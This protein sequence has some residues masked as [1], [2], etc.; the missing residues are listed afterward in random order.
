MQAVDET[1]DFIPGVAGDD[2][3]AFLHLARIEIQ[4]RGGATRCYDEPRRVG[5]GLRAAKFAL[6]RFKPDTRAIEFFPDV[7]R[8]FKPAFFERC[9]WQLNAPAS[10]GSARTLT[11]PQI[12]FKSTAADTKA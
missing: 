10:C 9:E 6:Y 1:G 12:R 4:V 2:G 3:L 7:G 8:D 5:A 11:D